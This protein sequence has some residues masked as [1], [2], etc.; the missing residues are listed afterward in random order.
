MNGEV[1]SRGLKHRICGPFDDFLR[2]FQSK[3]VAD[4][5]GYS[6]HRGTEIREQLRES[7]RLRDETGA[8]YTADWL[9]PYTFHRTIVNPDNGKLKI[10]SASAEMLAA[11]TIDVHRHGRLCHQGTLSM[12]RTLCLPNRSIR[13]VD[14]CHLWS[15]CV[16]RTPR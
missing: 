12:H 8:M 11:R 3:G 10:R 14:Q 1:R 13:Q 5:N 7:Q 16:K 9:V 15:D 6:R 4:L 2:F